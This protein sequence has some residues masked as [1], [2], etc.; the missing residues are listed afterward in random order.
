MEESECP[1]SVWNLIVEQVPA[2]EPPDIRGM[3][4]DAL[5]DMYTEIH[6][7]VTMWQQIWQT[8][9]HKLGNRLK[10]PHSP[11]ADPPAIKEL[12]K[13]E[14]QLLLGTVRERAALEGRDGDA[15]IFRYSPSVVNYALGVHNNRCDT[16]NSRPPSSGIQFSQS[17]H[18][19]R[20]CSQ[21]SDSSTTSQDDIDGVRH[22]LNVTHIDD[23][24]AHLN[25]E[26]SQ[27]RAEWGQA[28]VSAAAGGQ[29]G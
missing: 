13:A 29:A 24:V 15:D 14:I 9:R 2:P 7:E 8:V 27:Q 21:S 23:V 20:S 12:L 11:L 26:A 17:Q 3:F 19:E 28:P 25:A 6:T 22:K 1:L 4:G 10:T 5:I 18:A 16:V